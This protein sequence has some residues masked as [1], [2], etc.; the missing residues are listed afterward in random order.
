MLAGLI[1]T[2]ACSRNTS[3]EPVPGS[4]LSRSPTLTPQESGTTERLQAISVVSERVAW[5]SGT[6]GTYVRTTDGGATWHA[7]VVPGADSLEFRDV[8]AA[9][10]ATAW[11]MS[12]GSGPSSRIYHTTDA[13]AHWTLQFINAEPE[14]FYDCF[15]FWDRRSGIAFSDNVRGVFPILRT[16]DGGGHWDLLSDPSAPSAST[17]PPATSGE[18]AFAASGTCLVTQD[19]ASAW[20]GTGAGEQARVLFTPDRGRTWQ[21]FATPIV[22]GKNTQGITSI[23]FRDANHGFAVGG[24][25]GTVD[26]FSDNVAVTSDGGRTWSLGGRPPFSGAIFGAVYLPVAGPTIVAVGP[27]GAAFSTTEGREWSPLDSLGYWSAGF[28]SASAGWLVGPGGRITK[29]RF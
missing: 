10:A 29:V 26:G 4:P 3:D 15:G 6:G 21:S 13:G 8:H 27:N 20:I 18:G 23:G 1:A 2:A 17:A 28:A 9:D 25:I 16:E 22:Q 5:A 24:D 14:G 12:S 19:S 11:L 7:A